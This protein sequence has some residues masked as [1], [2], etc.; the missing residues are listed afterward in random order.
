MSSEELVYKP[1]GQPIYTQQAWCR[2]DQARREYTG[3]EE[4]GLV[5]GRFPH[6]NICT[7]DVD[8]AVAIKQISLIEVYENIFMGNF[9]AGFKT[10][11]LIDA[12]IT[13]ILNVTCKSYTLRSKYFKY[14]NLQLQDEKTE[15]AKK[16]FRATNRFIQEALDQ[17]GKVLVQSVEG[18][19]RS[20]TFILAYMINRDRRQLRDCLAILRQYVPEAEPNEGFMS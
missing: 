15:D 16:N 10:K 1:G 11:D 13:H 7:C 17:G 20:A 9:Q 6:L 3:E 14:Y 4:D 8:C 12:G 2:Y 19:S 18:R 5:C